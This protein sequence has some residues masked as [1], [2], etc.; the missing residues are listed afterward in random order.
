M[1]RSINTRLFGSWRARSVLFYRDFTHYSGGHRKVAD[2]FSHLQQTRR[3]APSIA[4]SGRTRWDENN[5]WF[6]EFQEKQVEFDPTAYDYLFLAGMDWEVYLADGVDPA[7]PVINLIQH[8]RHAEPLQDVYR[9]LAQRGGSDLRFAGSV[10]GHCRY[11]E[12]ERARIHHC[13]RAFHA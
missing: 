6:P 13:E 7:I 2:Y 8:V 10:G 11:G 9:F 3:Y 1:L 5:P 12:R 4:F